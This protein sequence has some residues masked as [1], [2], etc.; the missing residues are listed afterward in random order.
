MPPA[1]I[2]RF[3]IEKW[4]P[5]SL[6]SGLI[7]S[8]VKYVATLLAYLRFLARN[9]HQTQQTLGSKIQRPNPKVVLSPENL[10]SVS[11]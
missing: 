3:S 10:A 5:A 4:N 6:K 9:Q 7:R 1:S 2:S 11:F 8:M